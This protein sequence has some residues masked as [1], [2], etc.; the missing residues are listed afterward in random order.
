MY[1]DPVFNDFY[2]GL[3][4]SRGLIVRRAFSSHDQVEFF[5]VYDGR[6][7]DIFHSHHISPIRDDARLMVP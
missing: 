1:I 4:Y 2:D 6:D 7:D 3:V 5:Y